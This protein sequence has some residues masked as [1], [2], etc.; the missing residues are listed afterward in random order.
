MAVAIVTD[1]TSDI[2]PHKANA[3]G[4]TVVP[5]FVVFGDRS[6]KDYVELS[7]ADFY[8]KLK[9]EPVLPIT[10]QPTAAMYEEAF[11]PL[12]AAGNEVLCI[13]I[14]SHLSGTMNAAR[15]G[16]Q[17]FPNA[18]ITI[19]DSQTVAAGLGMM[20]LRARELAAGGA[21]LA[22]IVSELDRWR[23]TQRLYACI[24]DL[25]HL[26]RTGRIGKAKAALGTL[27]K[28]VPV[29]ALKDGQVAAEAQVRTFAR[30]QET[31]LDLVLRGAPQP[32]RA[33]FVVVHTNAPQLAADATAKLRERIGEK[34]PLLLEIWEAGP[35]IATHAGAGAVGA[36]AVTAA[37]E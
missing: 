22:A 5:L 15:A 17:R 10:S 4:I 7:R 19:Y 13:A 16:A 31:M 20:V 34:A 30:A 32:E 18:S 1:S 23:V 37:A 2:E 12:V 36:F 29:L 3:V 24:P 25:S 6:Y 8:E 11:G 26:Q 27:M 28:I 35:V 21:T 14:S 33:R 9:T